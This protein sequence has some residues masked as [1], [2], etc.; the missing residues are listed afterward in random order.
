MQNNDIADVTLYVDMVCVCVCMCSLY[1]HRMCVCVCVCVV[2]IC[3]KQ[4]LRAFRQPLPTYNRAISIRTCWATTANKN[5]S[6]S[7]RP[8]SVEQ[9]HPPASCSQLTHPAAEPI[10]STSHPANHNEHLPAMQLQLA[11]QDHRGPRERVLERLRETA[12]EPA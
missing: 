1:I 4:M 7:R 9:K 3:C 8:T 12:R 10:E 6:G 5:S 11:D 2:L